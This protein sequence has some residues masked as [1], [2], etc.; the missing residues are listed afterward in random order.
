MSFTDPTEELLEKYHKA[1][2]HAKMGLWQLEFDTQIFHW[3]E[4]VRRFY[5]LNEKRYQGTFG[6]W[7]MR[8]HPEDIQRVRAEFEAA[9]LDK[10]ELNTLC[11]LTVE[12]GTLRYTRLNAFKIRDERTNEVRGLVG[13]NWDVSNEYQLHAE[14]KKSQL[15]FEK[16]LDAIPDPVFIKDREHKNIFANKEFESITGKSKLE[17]VGREDSE[18]L[19]EKMA[20]LHRNEDEDLF[21]NHK[22]SEIEEIYEDPRGGRRHLLTKKTSLKISDEETILVG[23]IRDITDIKMI[24]NS[25]IEQ[26]KMA[27]LGEMAAE[28]A[29]EI[30]N[31]LMIIQAKS[32]IV[33]ER[34]AQGADQINL[35]KLIQDLQSI[36]KNS[37]RIDKIIKSLKSISRKSDQDPFEDVSIRRILEEAIEISQERLNKNHIQLQFNC[38]EIIDYS[39]LVKARPSELVQVLMNLLNNSFDA[40]KGIQDPW[41]KINLKLNGS[42]FQIEVL[43]SGELIRPDVAKRMMEPFFTTKTT[44]SGT[45]LGLSVSKQILQNHN[46]QLFYDDKSKNTKFVIQIKRFET[47]QQN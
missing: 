34:L 12:D 31:P 16:I 24:Q 11:R 26:S 18:F 25:M 8:V 46:G 44:G 3:D 42:I 28:I 27:S 5:E 2:G 14:L 21:E 10:A 30:N 17:M 41:V 43:D 45:G 20:N 33:L 32:Q 40:I 47:L 22:S 1:L 19:P 13:M 29:H 9:R 7:I 4:G 37:T 6:N 23:V 39:Y 35:P 36:E 15:F 38:E